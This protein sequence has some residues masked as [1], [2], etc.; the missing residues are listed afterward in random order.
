MFN[1]DF[2]FFTLLH[3]FS[4]HFFKF[5]V[6]S[7]VSYFTATVLLFDNLMFRDKSLKYKKLSRIVQLYGIPQYKLVRLS[8]RVHLLIYGIWRK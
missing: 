1:G 3:Y 5:K 7:I 6:K 8:Y 2:L 4:L